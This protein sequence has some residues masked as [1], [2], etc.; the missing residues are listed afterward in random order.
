MPITEL[1]PA[2]TLSKLLAFISLAV[3]QPDGLAFIV[4]MTPN[5]LK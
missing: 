3:K 2:Y 4:S 1:K 5:F